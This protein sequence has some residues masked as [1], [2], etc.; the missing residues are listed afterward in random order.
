MNLTQAA[1]ILHQPPNIFST[2]LTPTQIEEYKID[3]LLGY[4]REVRKSKSSESLH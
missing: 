3:Q 1:K 2:F 4:T